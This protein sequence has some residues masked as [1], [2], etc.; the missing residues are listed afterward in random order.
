MRP[1]VHEYFDKVQRRG[2]RA[3]ALCMAV[4]IALIVES[5]GNSQEA[6]Q[7]NTQVGN[8]AWRMPTIDG[9][10]WQVAGNPDLGEYTGDK[11]Q[12]VDFGIWQAADG[13]WQI[14]SCIRGTKCGGMTRLFHGWEG[15]NLTDSNWKPL[16]ITW[17]AETE[18]GETT[19]GMQA[20]HVV[21][22]DDGSY[23]MLYGDWINICR[24]TSV[25]GKTFQRVVQPNGRTKVFSEGPGYNTRDAM[26][27]RTKGR[28]YTYYTAYPY[29]QGM[30][31]VRT[32]DDFVTWSGSNPVAYGGQAGI[33]PW[34]TECPFVAEPYPGHYYLFHT[35]SYGLDKTS[36]YYST[37]PEYFGI[38]QDNK[39][40]AGSLAVAAPEVFEHDGQWYIAALNPD[41][42]GIRIAKLAWKKTTPK[43]LPQ[44]RGNGV[45]NFY[46]SQGREGWKV[47]EGNLPKEVFTTSR[48]FA[49][50]PYYHQFA[51]TSETSSGF[52]D[53]LIG[54]IESPVF[55]I[56]DDKYTV[57][58]GGGKDIEKLF[59]ALT[60]VDT[61]EE[62]A[63][64]TGDND[65]PMTYRVV[66]TSRHKGA[67][68]KIRMV[69]RKKGS[70]AKIHFG[71][72]FQVD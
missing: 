36:V 30:V 50:N 17:M 63:R 23:E 13:T 24:A 28:W 22:K 16:G 6:D 27:L 1:R 38:N 31:W 34:N 70:W 41:L 15:N 21:L 66:D 55:E 19:G 2:S 11:Q 64:W 40:F 29:E 25:D 42:D 48:R 65:F 57:L 58:V 37:N 49:F 10:W 26:T 44:I 43:V 68:A 33:G 67:R 20:P 7:A 39:Y 52:D 54:V 45:F 62:I 5:T 72:I 69:D 47:V 59:V 14:W 9:D 46:R 53:D 61:G 71:G 51:S 18:Y 32:S 3:T 12:P 4:A 8:G 35:Q 60:N 56:Q